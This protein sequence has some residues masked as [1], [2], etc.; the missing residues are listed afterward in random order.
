MRNSGFNCV[1]SSKPCREKASFCQ[2]SQSDRKNEKL[3]IKKCFFHV[4][5]KLIPY[6]RLNIEKS[7]SNCTPQYALFSTLTSYLQC[8]HTSFEFF[9]A[10]KMCSKRVMRPNAN[11][12]DNV[13]KGW[14]HR[15]QQTM[16]KRK[17]LQ[18]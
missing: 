9:D 8:N 2:G 7:S 16:G 13:D 14:K 18:N 17:T 15:K 11:F 6:P 4:L 10:E 3:H 5:R 1:S 12:D